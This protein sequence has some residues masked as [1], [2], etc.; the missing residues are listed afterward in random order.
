LHSIDVVIAKAKA[1]PSWRGE[2]TGHTGRPKAL[3]PKDIKRVVNLVF[4]ERGRARVTIAFCKKRLPFLRRVANSTVSLALC[5]AGLAWLSRRMKSFVPP[6]SKITRLAYSHWLLARHQATLAR[7]AYTDG[8]T[9]YLARCSVENTDKRR[10]ALGKRVW[11]MS[12][13]KDGLWSDNVGPSLYAKGQG[14][15]VKVWGFFG[16]GRLEYYVLPADPEREGRTTNM[17]GDRYEWLVNRKMAGWRAACFGDDE[18]VHFVQ[19]HERCLWQERNLVALRRA[20]CLVVSMYPKHSP[21]MN[22]I[23]G[24]WKVL[25]GRLADTEP[26]DFEDAWQTE[27]APARRRGGPCP[28]R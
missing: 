18:P 16:N 21:D 11:R 14:L 24:W 23:E 27:P 28:A 26:P 20:G 6:T 15:P 25:R 17:N 19:D 7:F 8:T 13:G 9:F 3:S 22:A 12:N 2:E 4:K 1:E 10:A 5:D